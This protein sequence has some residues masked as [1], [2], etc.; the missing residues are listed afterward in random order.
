MRKRLVYYV[1]V[2]EKKVV[3]PR[4]PLLALR[5]NNRAGVKLKRPAHT[6]THHH[7]TCF[8][9]ELPAQLASLFKAND[10]TPVCVCVSRVCFICT[11]TR[12]RGRDWVVVYTHIS[13]VTHRNNNL[14]KNKINV[15]I[16]NR[17]VL[18]RGCAKGK[19][20]KRKT[21]AKR[22]STLRIFW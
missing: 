15:F 17:I 1:L 3:P 16:S 9:I 12:E 19:H 2:V 11:I 5:T 8:N 22:N 7:A 18:R 10:P 4:R 21:R 14:E 13:H 20:F 6:H